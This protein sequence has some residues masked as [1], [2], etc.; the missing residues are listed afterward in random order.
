MARCRPS[1]RLGL[2]GVTAFLAGA[3]L[4][5]GV[6]P[7]AV[8]GSGRTGSSSRGTQSSRLS[9]PVAPTFLWSKYGGPRI[10][11]QGTGGAGRGGR[12]ALPLN[13]WLGWTDGRRIARSSGRPR[14]T[15][16]PGCPSKSSPSGPIS[17]SSITRR[18]GP[19][20]SSPTPAS[21]SADSKRVAHLPPV[22]MTRSIRGLRRESDGWFAVDLAEPRRVIAV[23]VRVRYA[24]RT[25][26]AQPVSGLPGSPLPTGRSERGT[27]G[28]SA[29]PRRLA[30]SRASSS[31][32]TGRCRFPVPAR[33]GGPGGADVLAVDFSR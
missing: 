29:T 12:L 22:R 4:L 33:C 17:S 14:W 5:A 26:T 30:A 32:S 11:R 2:F 24:T 27:T 9:L 16:G 7:G 13:T 1:D 3:F 28:C 23:R 19:R 25:R 8:G 18:P 6:W 15:C 31:G 21:T 20:R 10:L